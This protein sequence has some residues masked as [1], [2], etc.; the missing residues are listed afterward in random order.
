M[1]GHDLIH[2]AMEGFR[3]AVSLTKAIKHDFIHCETVP[4]VPESHELQML[5]TE[6]TDIV[7]CICSYFTISENQEDLQILNR[8]IRMTSQS[9]N[10]A[11][12]GTVSTELFRSN[13]SSIFYPPSENPVVQPQSKKRQA[14]VE[15]RAMTIRQLP[16]DSIV[17]FAATTPLT[18]RTVK[19]P[20]FE[21]ILHRAAASQRLP[22]PHKL[23]D[24]LK[25]LQ[26][27]SIYQPVPQYKKFCQGTMPS[28]NLILSEK[29]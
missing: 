17:Y 26:S 3:A 18:W 15:S 13:I 11:R 23:T 27:E 14:T 7:S 4:P 29:R 16:H 6:L 21:I 25:S 2:H 22:V 12:N 10:Q 20:V 19:G 9:R 5:A 24:Q 28:L 8:M 1:D